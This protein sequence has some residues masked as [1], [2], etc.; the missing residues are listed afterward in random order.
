MSLISHI[1]IIF[2]ITLRIQQQNVMRS[3]GL[4]ER[5]DGANE[6]K[7]PFGCALRWI[8]SQI[9]Y[10]ISLDEWM[11]SGAFKETTLAPP[12]DCIGFW[13][14]LWMTGYISITNAMRLRLFSN[15][16]FQHI[17]K[18]SLCLNVLYSVFD[19]FIF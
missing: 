15:M 13:C 2:M 7:H 6:S 5:L 4:L 8:I 14:K 3:N 19:N 17:F 10:D 12:S 16:T 18:C 1:Y 9:L 11:Q